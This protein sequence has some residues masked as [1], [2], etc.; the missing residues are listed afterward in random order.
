MNLQETTVWVGDLLPAPPRIT[1]RRVNQGFPEFTVADV[2]V[3]GAGEDGAVGG[4]GEDGAVGGASPAPADA[5]PAETVAVTLDAA[6]IDPGLVTDDGSDLRVE[7]ITVTSGHSRAAADLVTA[8]ATMIAQDPHQRPP[9][10]GLILPDLGWHVDEKMT[11]KHG[12]LVP[13]FLWEDGV[14]H[15]HEV[16]FGGR[17]GGGGH[18]DWTHPGRMTVVAQL[19]MLTDAEFATATGQGLGAVQR[20]LTEAEV[21]LNDVWR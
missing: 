3:G 16:D 14:P 9:R 8:A 17:H 11:A 19:V 2:A 5:Q 13:P 15:V 4:A 18:H 12:L 1:T 20:Q 10:P 21:N 7:L 6:R